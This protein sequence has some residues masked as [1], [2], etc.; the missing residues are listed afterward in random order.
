MC[1]SR[2]C[3]PAVFEALE[4]SVASGDTSL[5]GGMRL[6]AAADRLRARDV[7]GHIWIDVDTRGDQRR[8]RDWLQAELRK[9]DDGLRVG[10]GLPARA[11]VASASVERSGQNRWG[12]RTFETA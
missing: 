2:S 11:G 9:P 3:S 8:A 12:G 4:E 1:S 10:S 5:S 6:L 7:T